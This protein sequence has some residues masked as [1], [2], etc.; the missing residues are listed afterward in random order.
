MT[1]PCVNAAFFDSNILVYA[2][3]LRDAE[4]TKRVAAR[5][6]FL[7]RS[8]V[9][10]TQVLM[11]TFNVIMKIGLAARDDA[12]AY[13]RRLAANTV[14]ML[15]GEDVIRA[16]EAS[17]RFEISHWDGLIIRAAEKAGVDIVYSEDL[18]HGQTYG[19]V[20]VCNPFIEDFLA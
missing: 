18:N 4:R 2:I 13:V 1:R 9:L 6:L 14:M 12:E 19:K 16:I 15:N 17:G 20:R 10:S 3:D 8:C 11:E 5:D 7:K